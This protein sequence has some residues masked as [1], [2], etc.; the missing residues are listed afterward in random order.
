MASTSA[1]TSS[2][3]ASSGSISDRLPALDIAARSVLESQVLG[4]TLASLVAERALEHHWEGL[5]Q[6]AALRVGSERAGE[7]LAQLAQELEDGPR[8][9]LEPAP[10]PRARLY[11]QMR[12]KLA[13][14][15]RKPPHAIDRPARFVP[16]VPA[17]AT[18]LDELRRGLTPP[19]AELLELHFARGLSVAE[20]AHVVGAELHT[21]GHALNEL[22]TRAEH[23]LGRRP[24][25][26]DRSLAGAL[27]EA[28]ALD[29]GRAPAPRRR[30][31]P[32]VLEV[33]TVIAG[34]YEIEAKL[35][36]G[37]FAE[38][39]RARDRDVVDHVVALKILRRPAADERSVQSAL[40]E[41][42]LIASVFHPSVVA[43]KDHGWHGGRLW[44]VMPLYR[45]E[46]LA[47][48][49]QRGPVSRSEARAIFEPLA[50]ALAT[51]HRS[52]VLHQDIKPEN[53]FLATLDA[54]ATSGGAEG[55]GGL[56]DD[57][58]PRGSESG[59][60]LPVLLDLGVAAKDAELVLAGTPAYFAP[61]MAARFAGVPDPAPVGP[62]ADV[63]SLAL[64]LRRA[65]DPSP[66]E[67]NMV[68]PVDAFVAFRAAHAPAAPA[69]RELRDL[70]PY[71]ERWLS[72]APDRRPSA[73]ELRVELSA[74]TRPAERRERRLRVLRWAVPTVVTVLALFGTTTYVLSREAAIQRLQAATAR[75]RADQARERAANMLESLTVQQ[76]RRRELEAD[77]ARLER[78]YQSSRMTR[79]ELA[80]H[81]AQAE[82]E[83]EVQR[84]ALAQRTQKQADDARAFREQRALMVAELEAVL[85]V[86][87]ELAQKLDRA[88]DQ[89]ESER[90]RGSAS[91]ASNE[92]L[93]EQLASARSELEL[94]RE[95]ERDAQTQI[96]LL[97]QALLPPASLA[98]RAATTSSS[99]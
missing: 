1:A 88:G 24:P 72:F 17:F 50:E 71:F 45:G 12:A 34:R 27:L 64:T 48:R 31:R 22:W 92:Q 5:Y 63:F 97:R 54:R 69:A 83:L 25:S 20:V 76:A 65:L 9:A 68:G 11:E 81:L 53:V 42:Q 8:D 74:L 55:D 46:T 62:K 86:R 60:I 80:T 4:V 66:A 15:T 23:T 77:V 18:Q 94:A 21:V 7:L 36:S 89:L 67:P 95:R 85:D 16:P 73:E 38:V 51:M 6:Y 70:K 43:L 44:L 78:E 41:L 32:P 28:F 87:N 84:A 91:A 56:G 49:L 39:Y 96:A 26:R 75:V 14:L 59:R 52:G 58:E 93:R 30:M 3:S 47:A 98:K 82:G 35:G 40:R 37:A 29:P 61:E 90:A 2:V 33:G 79:D 19:E 57:G 10:G 99:K 13:E